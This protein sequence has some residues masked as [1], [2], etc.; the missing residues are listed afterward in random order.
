MRCDV[1]SQFSE[2]NIKKLCK[3]SMKTKEVSMV[4]PFLI[5]VPFVEIS[6]FV[7]IILDV[8]IFDRILWKEVMNV[9]S[10][11]RGF[12]VFTEQII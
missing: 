12:T 4:K 10:C 2:G 3:I 1:H 5:I 11:F 9:S 6:S 7:W 8:I